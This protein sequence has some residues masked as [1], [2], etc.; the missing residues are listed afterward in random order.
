MKMKYA[1]IVICAA[2]IGISDV[3]AYAAE[4][5][6]QQ[7]EKGMVGLAISGI[8]IGILA[9]YR[10]I[11]PLA[12]R[13]MGV[14][15]YGLGTNDSPIVTK[16]EKLFSVVVTPAVYIP[17]PV[18]FLDP[19]LFFG[20]SYSHYRWKSPDF[21]MNGIINDITF[22]GGAG[23]GFIVAHFCRIGVNCWINYD[24]S[25]FTDHGVKEK[26]RRIALPMPFI[27]ICFMF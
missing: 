12:I 15:V 22:G 17:T 4:K 9:E 11:K 16:G 27:D 3:H 24:Y 2:F 21:K 1:A 13:V 18:D 19:V 6:G 20:I 5:T 25:V 10:F 8:A 14:S 7:R 23:I 26:G